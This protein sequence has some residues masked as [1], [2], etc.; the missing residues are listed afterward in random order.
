MVSWLSNIEAE[1]PLDF[2][3]PCPPCI[4]HVSSLFMF[5]SQY[6]GNMQITMIISTSVSLVK[7][8]AGFILSDVSSQSESTYLSV[9]FLLEFIC[10]RARIS[11][12]TS[13]GLGCKEIL[14]MVFS[15]DIKRVLISDNVDSCCKDVLEQNGITVDVKT[16]LTKD[17]LLSE[18]QVSF[19]L[20]ISQ[21]A[22]DTG[23]T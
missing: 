11:Q 12:Q 16:K 1:T 18:I 3:F 23:V 19:D 9:E 17:E 2:F 7:V 6:P 21:A 22:V 8:F 10:A 14:N 4:L 5:I 15:T 13:E 20:N